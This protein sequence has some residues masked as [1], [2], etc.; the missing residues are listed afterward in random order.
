MKTLL[1]LL[2]FSLLLQHTAF[3]AAQPIPRDEAQKVTLLLNNAL[4][5]ITDG[6]F[7]LELNAFKPHGVKGDGMAAAI[8]VPVHDLNNRIKSAR[9]G[10][11]VPVGQLWLHKIVPVVN[12]VPAAKK[13]L[14]R[15]MISSDGN[16]TLVS[17]FHLGFRREGEKNRLL[18]YGK[19]DHVLLEIPLKRL[20][21]PQASPIELGAEATGDQQAELVIYL[22]DLFEGK[23]GLRPEP[24]D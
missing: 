5:D 11:I 10:L 1:T 22:A 18:V 6:P 15:V 12:D 9:P 24:A 4:G 13:D 20:E 21:V 3:A 2:S 17:L 14:R 19:G 8:A 7:R 16:E 23:M